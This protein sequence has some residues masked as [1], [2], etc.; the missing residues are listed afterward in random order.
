MEQYNPWNKKIDYGTDRL[1]HYQ[2]IVS[3]LFRKEIQVLT[4]IRRCGKTTLLRQCMRYLLDKGIKK[5]Q[6]IFIPCDD[7]LLKIRNFEDL[8]RILQNFRTKE[9]LFVFLDEIQVIEGWERYVKS[10]YDSDS[11]MKFIIT[12]ST[13]SF[14]EKDVASY[15]T[16]RHIYHEIRTLTYKEY[17]RL[18][19]N[20]SLLDYAEWGGFP[21]VVKTDSA[22]QKS[23][24]LRNYLQTII[25]RDIIKRNRLRNEKKVISLLHA[26]ISVVGGKINMSR[27]SN[28]FNIS[29]QTIERYIGIGVDA[30]LFEE[31]GFFS[32]SRRKHVRK[33]YKLYP[34]DYG[35]C[36]IINSRFEKGR[37]MEWAVLHV[38]SN[39][40][41]W[42]SNGHEV[43]FVSKNSAIQ[44]CADDEIP[45][46]EAESLL[47]FRK[48][49][50]MRGILLSNHTT[51]KT[52][53][54]EEF[55]LNPD[56]Q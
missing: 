36:R 44:V 31:V 45:E 46:R 40:S 52:V 16:G 38:L 20:G 1:F 37:A 3:F 19:P 13:A 48:I 17:L 9:K 34:V 41:Y 54:I 26:L 21:E 18:K 8:H 27:L 56:V 25:L 11:N 29:R 33:E 43:D 15:L 53:S 2:D 49:F 12:G 50:P 10:A 24:I 5:E 51:D 32:Y 7:P 14:F 47:A 23:L 28:Q 6:I 4:G 30:F 42:S 55:L 35:F 22:E 39:P